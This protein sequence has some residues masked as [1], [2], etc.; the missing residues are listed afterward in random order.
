MSIKWGVNVA[1]LGMGGASEGTAYRSAAWSAETTYDY[2]NLVVYE[3]VQYY[4]LQGSNLNNIP[5]SSP[6]YWTT[7]IYGRNYRKNTLA[8]MT[9]CRDHGFDYHRLQFK[10]HRLQ[11]DALNSASFNSAELGYLTDMADMIGGLGMKF[12]ICPFDYAVYYNFA[13]DTFYEIGSAEVPNATFATF[14]ANLVTIFQG[15]TYKPWAYDLMNEPNTLSGG[16]EQWFDAAQAAIT[17]IR[18]IDTATP[19]I[20]SGYQWGDTNSWFTDSDSLKDLVDP[21]DNLIFEGHQYFDAGDGGNYYDGDAIAGYTGDLYDR[22]KP[23]MQPFIEW[24]RHN[25]KVGLIGEIATPGTT[26]WLQ[27]LKGAWDYLEECDDVIQ[28]IQLQSLWTCNDYGY[29]WKDNYVLSVA[30]KGSPANADNC[31]GA[32]QA[33]TVFTYTNYVPNLHPGPRPSTIAAFTADGSWEC[34]AG[35]TRVAALVVAGGGSGGRAYGGGGGAGGVLYDPRHAVTPGQTYPI[36]VGAGGAAL[37]GDGVGND[38]GNSV[39]DD[40]TAVGGG[41]GGGG[42][43]FEGHNGGSGGGSF[44]AAGA[45]GT[46][47]PGQGNDGSQGYTGGAGGGAG[48]PGRGLSS[49]SVGFSV[50]GGGLDFSDVFGT[51]YGESGFFGGGGG[52]AATATAYG[53]GGKG[54]GGNGSVEGG[55][56]ATSATANTGGGG[57]GTNLASNSGG[58]GSGIVLIG[59]PVE[60]KLTSFTSVVGV[61]SIVVGNGG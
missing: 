52:G 16:Q 53:P 33:S 3:G 9:Y 50:G 56:A 59:Y 32:E 58:G 51:S 61:G 14:W 40:M 57:G 1:G 4:S 27:V 44:A 25:N 37:S 48:G 35:V 15:R 6:T 7:G 34:P 31:D 60:P 23:L 22:A 21:N 42:S 20:V 5:S 11:P 54:G 38:G 2:G 36:T 39:F 55:A 46:G 45:A 8:E 28:Y 24:C 30:P 12:S 47:I 19:I 49:G 43:H 13:N 18:A 41:G 26:F 10:W 29:S 17:A